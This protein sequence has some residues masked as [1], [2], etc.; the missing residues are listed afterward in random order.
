MKQWIIVAAIFAVL[1]GSYIWNRNKAF[2]GQGEEIPPVEEILTLDNGTIVKKTGDTVEEISPEE[3][4]QKKQ[5][6][7]QKLMDVEPITLTATEGNSG[8]GKAFRKIEDN[9]YYQKVQVE[10]LSPLQK[11]YYYEVWLEKEDGAV[12]SIGRLDMSSTSG[13]LLYSAQGDKS[14]YSKIVV[15]REI[16]DGDTTIGERVL[17]GSYK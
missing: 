10:G 16:E 15:S 12:N 9:A 13:E 11:G 17:E 8:T 5:E 14:Q 6:I 3:A 1:L 4:E 7:S 2:E